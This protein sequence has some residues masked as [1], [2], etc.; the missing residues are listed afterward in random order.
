MELHELVFYKEARKEAELVLD[1]LKSLKNKTIG[2]TINWTPYYKANYRNKTRIEINLPMVTNELTKSVNLANALC[3]MFEVNMTI[4][5]GINDEDIILIIQAKFYPRFEQLFQGYSDFL[6][7]YKDLKE[8]LKKGKP[9]FSIIVANRNI[10]NEYKV[11]EAIYNEPVLSFKEKEYSNMSIVLDAND[12][13][14]EE[15]SI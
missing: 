2:E 8:A 15:T 6:S 14:F 13:Q 11:L 9:S 4:P 10:R 1:E 3:S 12:I 7:Y 5:T